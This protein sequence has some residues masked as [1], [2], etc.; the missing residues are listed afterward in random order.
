MLSVTARRRDSSRNPPISRTSSA[1]AQAPGAH[2]M[3][4]A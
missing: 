4:Q 1:N 2:G 3:R